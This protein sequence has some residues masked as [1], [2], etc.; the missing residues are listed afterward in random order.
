MKFKTKKL[1]I[2]TGSIV[3][4]VMNSKDAQRY[5][6]HEGDRVEVYAG[7]KTSVAVLDI[8]DTDN[9]IPPGTLGLFE[10][11]HKHIQA[12][13]GTIV[14]V[15]SA[16]KPESLTYIKQKMA[17]IKLTA[18][19]ID[20]I[21]KDIVD[22]R[23]TDIEK[24]YFV[25]ACYHH[26][27]D[28][29][30]ITALTK[31]MINTG[32]TLKL[33]RNKP[34]LD[35]HCIGGVPGNRTTA[36]VVPIIAAAGLTIPKSSSRSITSPA[37]TSD[38]MEVLCDVCLSI[39]QMKQV[40]K[41]TGGC[42]VWGG[43]MNLAPADDK[44]I[45]IEHPIS[46]DPVGQLL[47][48]I[49]AK[50]KSVGATHVLIDIPLGKGAK[51][52]DEKH[53]QMLKKKFEELGKRLDMKVYVVITDGSQPIGNGI[54]P[55]LEARDLLW[56]IQD[57]PRASQMLKEKAIALSGILLEL[58]GKVRKGQGALLAR[59]LVESGKAAKKFIEI[60]QAQRA[61]HIQADTIPLGKFTYDIVAGKKGVIQ[62]I[63]NI[64]VAR[65][66]R[67]AGAPKDKGAGIYLYHHVHDTVD[68]ST[69]LYRIFAENKSK[70]EQSK[71]I[72]IQNSGVLLRK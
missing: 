34:I 42:L 35:K 59:E 10:E 50:K 52:D 39:D 5:S 51:I 67:I 43:A 41:K 30:E 36:L 54:G 31:A 66:A 53:A 7:K 6:F 32:T 72:A 47:A 3:I 57:D 70:L 49:L 62:H 69:V 37:G 12:E 21:I 44:I 14:E 38:T 64:Q 20:Q 65:V 16:N 24:T 71:R 60:I 48:S 11:L 23:L 17:G 13:N 68:A 26:E 19:Q 40:I 18:S 9:L 1:G 27:L 46:L 55:A 2:S 63:D 58:G 45:K 22:N 28:M 56:T 25:S 15:E 4:A 33:G 8:T 29:D 61:H